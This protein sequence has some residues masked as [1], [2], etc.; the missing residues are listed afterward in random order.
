MRIGF[1]GVRFAGLD[2]VSLESAKLANIVR[3]AGHEA[4]WFAGELG[5]GFEVGM[6]DPAA[7]FDSVDNVELQRRCFGVSDISTD[8]KET[9]QVR[10]SL[11]RKALDEF[12]SANAIDVLVP[13]NALA[14][15][16][17]LPLGLAL[18]D[19]IR[20]GIPAVAHHHDF[21][22]ERERFWPNGVSDILNE[23]F[24][25]VAPNLHHVVINSLAQRELM[26]R[27]GADSTVL[28][29]VMDFE[30][31]PTPGDGS[32]FR[33]HAGLGDADTVL[34]QSTRIV[35][36][37]AIELTL[38]LAAGLDEPGVRVV[39]SHPERDE[40]DEYAALLLKRAEDLGVD[41]RLTP[42]G[43]PGEPTLAD[44]YAAAD[45]V[46]FPSR[47][48][49]FGNALLEAVYF[50]RPVLVNRYPVYVS[51]IAP[52]GFRFIE[53]GG[54]I[55]DHTLA[56]VEMWLADRRLGEDAAAANYE[57]GLE[58]FSYAVARERFLPL[59]ESRR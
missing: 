2:G 46:T 47:V 18:T 8:V 56:E 19:L 48:E 59:L 39:I 15:P 6:E 51:D 40:G 22:W 13:Q 4:V 29:N 55:T 36:R 57:I 25:P 38:E 43:A 54:A 41:L 52:T 50:R 12:V 32:V 27:T 33:R 45:L 17:Q 28:P 35:P 14:I 24:P 3:A 44:A 42:V 7:R 37:K 1:V 34:L 20:G 26:D 49:G 53:I 31:E 9:I 16:V 5:E 23:A 58:R 30:H 11:L 10:T 21:S